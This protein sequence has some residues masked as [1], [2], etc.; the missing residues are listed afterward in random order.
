MTTPTPTPIIPTKLI[1]ILEFTVAEAT[2]TQ[3]EREVL[4]EVLRAI[5]SVRHGYIQLVLQDAQVVQ[6]ETTE[7]KRLDRA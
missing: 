3:R 1:E 6:I 7:K 5:R 2:V 4:Q